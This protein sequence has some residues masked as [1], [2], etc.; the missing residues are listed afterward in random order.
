M[1]SLIL[2][3]ILAQI[4]CTWA[5]GGGTKKSG[6]LKGCH[7]DNKR[8]E[9]HCHT[10]S[11]YPG[12][13]W[14]S[15]GE[16]LKSLNAS[17]P[18]NQPQSAFIDKSNS[19]DR[20][21]WGYGRDEEVDCQDTRAEILIAR[22]KVPVIFEGKKK[23]RVLEGEWEDFY[24]PVSYKKSSDVEIDHV[25]PLYNAHVSGGNM[26][27]SEQ[28]RRF[29]NDPEN[30]VVT[31]VTANRRKRANDLNT[32]IP[33]DRAY[34]CKYYERWMALK[35]KYSLKVTESEKTAVACP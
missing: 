16:A 33:S 23:C 27:N 9:F 8:G 19:Y 7:N 5:H 32:W 18:I 14:K 21:S 2:T 26:W 1:K 4:N 25:V 22:S 15:E 34:A 13:K 24:Y 12:K 11:Q 6:P 28:K 31:S 29:A 35:V 20:K 3:I 10:N 17:T 30:L